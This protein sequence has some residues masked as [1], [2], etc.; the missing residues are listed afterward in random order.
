MSGDRWDL[1]S[2]WEEYV[3]S[4]EKENSAQHIEQAALAI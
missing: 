2:S 3:L 4:S 1:V